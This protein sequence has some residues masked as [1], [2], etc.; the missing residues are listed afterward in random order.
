MPAGKLGRW[1]GRSLNPVR[2]VVMSESEKTHRL[3][4]V[5]RLKHQHERTTDMDPA[6]SLEGRAQRFVVERVFEN[7]GYL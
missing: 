2:F 7:L 4:S 1:E 3:S 6:Y 5:D